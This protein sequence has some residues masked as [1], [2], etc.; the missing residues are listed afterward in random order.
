MLK[1]LFDDET[2]RKI[3]CP[4]LGSIIYFKSQGKKRWGKVVLVNYYGKKDKIQ[5]GIEPFKRK[6]EN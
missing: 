4:D 2:Y 1:R 6:K 3:G 5:L